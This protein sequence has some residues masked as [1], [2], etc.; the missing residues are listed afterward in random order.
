M[1]DHEP[2][3]STQS[4]AAPE[5][6]SQP[7][8]DHDAQRV[9]RR[10]FLI[11]VGVVAS[12][13]T[14]L[15]GCETTQPSATTETVP[16]LE[17]TVTGV[18]TGQPGPALP[19]SIQFPEVPY[20][21]AAPPD[22]NVLRFFTPHEAQTVEA[23]TARILPGTPDDPGAREAGVVTYI[24]TMLATD[25]GFPEKTYRHPPYA[26]TYE[27]DTPPA[28]TGQQVIWI[29]K[30]E[31]TR[32]GYQ[33]ILS[34]RE[35]YRLGVAAVDRY[36]N[37]RFQRDYVDLSE[38]QQ[39]QIIADMVSGSATGFDRNLTPEAFF[40]TLRRHT[41]EGMFSDPVY[42]GN[43]DLIGW[44]LVGYPGAQRSYTPAELRTENYQRPP[45]SI[46][47]M[48][49]FNPGQPANP[50]VRLPVSGSEHQH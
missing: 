33:S 49:P 8:A 4:E 9:S 18:T 11:G 41:S 31:A 43:R 29:P 45:Q 15:A 34:P 10:G 12:A 13:A 32:Y 23:L 26:M 50:N 46:A 36:S 27:G 28:N 17:A 19:T 40:H 6:T 22:P 14:V 2:N 20:T 5:A 30:A 21:P 44:K 38:A 39:D 7:D 48:H 37:A 47:M 24:D 42:G 25:E 3:T 1:S 16:N 35:V